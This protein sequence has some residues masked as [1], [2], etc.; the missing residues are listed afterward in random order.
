MEMESLGVD[1][2]VSKYK[3]EKMRIED[4]WHEQGSNKGRI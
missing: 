2:L 3:K 4:R 1:L